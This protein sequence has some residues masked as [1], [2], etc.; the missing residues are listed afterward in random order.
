MTL[1]KLPHYIYVKIE[2]LRARFYNLHPDISIG[3]RTCIERRAIVRPISHWGRGKVNIGKNCYVGCNS[4][5]VP[6]EKGV[7]TIGDNSTINPGCF[8]YGAGGISIGNNVR[9]GPCCKIVAVNHVFKDPDIP[10]C[11]QGVTTLGITIEDDCWIGASS[12]ILDGVTIRSGSV[13][14]AGSVVNRDTLEKTV[15][16][17]VPAKPIK[18]RG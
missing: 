7:I 9:I 12:I 6:S 10:I 2:H 14:G 18:C 3:V 11:K 1:K 4:Q 17:G 15:Y 16:V 5:L 13:I 8:L